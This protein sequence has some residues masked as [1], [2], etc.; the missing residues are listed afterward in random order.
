MIVEPQAV[1]SSIRTV[2]KHSALYTTAELLKKAIGFIMIPLYTHYLAPADYGVIEI[3]NLILEVLAIIVGARIISA[4]TRYYHI[5]EDHREKREVYTTA[6]V[7]A[8]LLSAL[9]IATLW[10]ETAGLSR[11]TLGN[12]SYAAH[13]RLVIA[14]FAIQNIFLVGE[15]D[16]IIRK[17]SLFFSGLSIILMILSLSLNVLFLAVFH[18]GVWAI[19]WS[20]FITKAVNLV[21]VP[22]T[23]RGDKIRF[24]S[25]KLGQMLRYGL[26]L[27]PAS[28]AMFVIHFSDR[29]F[30]QRYCSLTDVGIYS[31]AY[32]FGMIISVILSTPFQRAW[33]THSFEIERRPES[34]VVHARIFTYFACI[35]AFLGLCISVFIEDAIA[36]LA[37]PS[38]AGAASIVPLI[39]LSYVLMGLG[40]MAALGIMLSCRTQY[41]TYIQVPAAAINI[42]LN[43]ALIRPYGIMGA[44]LATLLTFGIMFVATFWV[45]QRIYPIP[46]EYRRLA[47][48]TGVALALFAVGKLPSGPSLWSIF[49]HSAVLAA[50]PAS[51]IVFRFFAPHELA[52]ARQSFNRL[53]QWCVK[54]IS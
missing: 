51:L 22:A 3:L 9:S 17:R 15:N 20:I 32:K 48:L 6:L 46:Y 4:Q 54:P 38:Y 13:Y 19:L 31:L 21:V 26:P 16:L 1:N 50:F 47:I 28:L 24:S 10:G 41:M 14:C 52:V 23:L 27:V 11:L 5:Y 18:L 35:L 12:G 8:M 34:S 43:F 39:V 45:S 36:L 44:A 53:I 30:L 25:K 7:F 49:L 33:G 42:A 40:G 29:F 2:A 37:P